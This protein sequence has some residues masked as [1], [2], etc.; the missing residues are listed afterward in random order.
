M[1]TVIAPH[2]VHLAAA[3]NNAVNSFFQSDL[4]KNVVGPLLA[5]L[6]VV[7]ILGAVAKAAFDVL[8]GSKQKPVKLLVGALV[9]GILMIQPQL[10]GNLIDLVSSWVSAII[11]SI[12]G[13][14]NN[15]PGSPPTTVP[16][17]GG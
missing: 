9:V 17:V 16:P 10:I 14:T 1:H 5:F 8:Q 2:A 11:N 13:V 12:T 3:G 6:G 15:A 7:I 4:G